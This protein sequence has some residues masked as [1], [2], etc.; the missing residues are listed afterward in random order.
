MGE[1]PD[2][3]FRR[4]IALQPV[5]S[6]R[7]FRGRRLFKEDLVGPTDEIATLFLEGCLALTHLVPDAPQC[8]VGEELDNVPRREELVADSQL[9][10]VPR[11]LG[12]IPHGFAFFGRVEVLVDP[13][14]GLVLGPEV[15][16]FRLVQ[17]GEDVFDAA[18]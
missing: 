9:P 16:Q 15:R 3:G 8:V 7:C 5:L 17:F 10:A 18:L 4:L 1:V 6:S 12:G 13:S 11:S 2:V 14:D